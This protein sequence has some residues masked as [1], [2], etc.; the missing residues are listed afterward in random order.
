M[1]DHIY[2]RILNIPQEDSEVPVTEV[3][4]HLRH[5]AT[6]EGLRRRRVHGGWMLN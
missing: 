1:S 3:G 6:G 5:D 4:L 2:R